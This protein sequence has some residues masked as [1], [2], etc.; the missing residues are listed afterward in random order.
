M[1][2]KVSLIGATRKKE[3]FV[4]AAGAGESKTVHTASQP[5]RLFKKA[6]FNLHAA[7]HQRLKIAAAQHNCQMVELVEDALER[8]LNELEKKN[9]R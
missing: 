9:P 7:L 2:K 4:H 1:P 8:L 6:T 5:T 3:D